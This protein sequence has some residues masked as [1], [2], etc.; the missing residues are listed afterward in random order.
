LSVART[1]LLLLRLGLLDL[2]VHERK[3]LLHLSA[4]VRSAVLVHQLVLHGQVLAFL[5]QLRVA[6]TQQA[7]QRSLDGL[8]LVTQRLA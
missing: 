6:V 2:L 5:L 8:E 1:R 4:G 3:L 7:L